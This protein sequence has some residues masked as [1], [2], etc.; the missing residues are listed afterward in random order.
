MLQIDVLVEQAR[1]Y[2]V[3]AC[4]TEARRRS[5]RVDGVSLRV[6]VGGLLIRLGRTVAGDTRRVA[7]ATG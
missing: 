7:A 4:A 3:A 1:A 5:A 6:R 2:R